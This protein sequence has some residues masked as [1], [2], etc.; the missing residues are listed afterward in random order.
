VIG[1]LVLAAGGGARFGTEPKLLAEI[2][3]R[4]VLQHAIE[5]MTR[6]EELDRVVVVLGAHA[7]LLLARVPF[8]RADGVICSRWREGQSAS[9]RRGVDALGGAEKIVVTLGDQPLVT[10]EMVERL[11]RAPAGSRAAYRGRPGHPAVLGPQHVRQIEE[12]AGDEGARAI[13][14]GPLIEAAD[15]GIPRDLDTQED[16]EQ[17]RREVATSSDRSPKA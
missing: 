2:D 7:D 10:P 6:V 14:T 13:L 9:L 16:L 1:G 15:L 8:G 5:T 3:G 11:I 4:P 17:V 12:L